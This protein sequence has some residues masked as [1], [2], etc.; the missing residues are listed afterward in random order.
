MRMWCR[1]THARTH[2][3]VTCTSKH[4]H[5]HAHAHA[6]T[7][8]HTHTHT[9][10]AVIWANIRMRVECACRVTPRCVE[11][12]NT[13]NAVK[14]PH[15][16]WMPLAIIAR[17]SKTRSSHPTADFQTSARGSAQ[18]TINKIAGQMHAKSARLTNSTRQ[19]AR[20]T[21]PLLSRLV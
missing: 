10:A 17:Q 2:T 7:R 21:D 14:R 18:R 12:G 19:C 13:G 11:S 1:K 3:H 6:H 5:A 20:L 8:T 4:A 16:P 9:H 15:G